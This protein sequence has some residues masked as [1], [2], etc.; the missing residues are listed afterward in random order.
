MN[1][2]PIGDR[3]ILLMR[4]KNVSGYL[5]DVKFIAWKNFSI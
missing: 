3:D 4:R 5:A 1:F 2:N